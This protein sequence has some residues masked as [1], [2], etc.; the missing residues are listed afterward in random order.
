M[1]VP[2]N[3]FVGWLWLVSGIP[4]GVALIVLPPSARLIC[5][6]IFVLLETGHS[7][8]PIVLAWTHGGFRRVM[9]S[10]TRKYV[11]LPVA[12]FMIVLVIGAVTSLGWTSLVYGPGNLWSLTEWTNPFPVVVWVYWV[13]NIYH[14]GMQ[15]FGVLSLWR[16]GARSRRRRF[17]DMA[18]CLIVTAFC[19]AALPKLTREEWVGFLLL[20]AFSVN[21]WVVDIGLSSRVLKRGWLFIV[22]VLAAGAIGFLLEI[23]TPNGSLLRAIPILLCAR[24]GLGFVHFLYSRWVWKLSDARVRAT[25]GSFYTAPS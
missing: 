14:F 24:M 23:P 9:L 15:H 2:V 13:W 3:R 4:V 21:H 18:L 10:Q 16:G 22:G 12:V 19:M 20:G 8:S 11:V 6:A 1:A 7:L 5:F 17:A 25:I